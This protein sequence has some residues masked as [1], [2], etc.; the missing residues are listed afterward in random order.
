MIGYCARSE[1]KVI[2]RDAGQTGSQLFQEPSL[3]K[4]RQLLKQ[5]RATHHNLQNASPQSAHAGLHG[6][7]LSDDLRPRLLKSKPLM[8]PTPTP[9]REQTTQNLAQLLRPRGSGCGA[10]RPSPITVIRF[11]IH[12]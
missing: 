5:N 11:G 3:L 9:S 8:P 2:N 10:G 7:L 4:V 12:P 1:S 6:S